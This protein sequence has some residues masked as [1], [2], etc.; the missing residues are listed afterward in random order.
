MKASA[1]QLFQFAASGALS[2]IKA[3]VAEGV[4]PAKEGTA[5]YLL[6][7][8]SGCGVVGLGRPCDL[9]EC[10]STFSLAFSVFFVLAAA[11]AGSFSHHSVVKTHCL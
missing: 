2:N 6:N 1:A 8:P 4:N 5:V 11:M 9:V 3:L 7:P 10:S